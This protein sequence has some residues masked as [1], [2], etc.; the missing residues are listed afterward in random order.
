MTTFEIHDSAEARRF[1]TQGLWLQRVA[2]PGAATVGPALRWALEVVSAG[3]P[4]PPVGVIADVGHLLLGGEHHAA[5]ISAGHGAPEV[6]G[7]PSGLARRYEDLVLGKLDADGTIARASDALSRYRGRDRGRGLAFVLEQVHRRAG[8]GGVLLNP[9]ALKAALEVPPDELLAAGWDML[10]RDGPMPALPAL[11]ENWVAAVRDMHDVLGPEDV[12]ELEHG[13]ALAAFSQRVGLRQVLQAAAEFEVAVPLARPRIHSR[14]YDFA[15][16]ILDEDSYPVGGFSSIS[17]RGSIESLLHS[18]L[19]YMEPGE[20]P[21]LFDIKFV[22]DELLYYARDENQFFRRR[23]TFVLALH[24]DLTLARVK[25]V[26]LPRQRVVLALGLLVALVR[27]L[28]DWLSDEAI[29]FEFLFIRQGDAEP[30]AAEQALVEMILREAIANGTVL[31]DSVAEDTI[32]PRCITRARRSFCQALTV[33]IADR[34]I[35]AEGVPAATLRLDHPRPSFQPGN[36]SAP[37]VEPE[38]ADALASWHVALERLL[39]LWA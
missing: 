15:T 4:M 36:E 22:R 18:Q 5:A 2:A 24:P 34:R 6:P 17:T 3:E 30:M 8:L 13:T 20:R 38:S 14:R 1:L 12:F 21:D 23:R 37:V 35:L 39:A 29:V 11:Y 26:E 19:A 31:T 10:A 9:A 16:R 28:T 25:D 32:A 27:R 33:T 7:W